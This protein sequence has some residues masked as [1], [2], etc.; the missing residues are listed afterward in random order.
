RL[1]LP[2]RGFEHAAASRSQ[3]ESILLRMGFGD[4]SEG[5]GQALPRDYVTGESI[6]SVI[7]D[8]TGRLW[9]AFVERF[10]R[11][12]PASLEDLSAAIDR[13]RPDGACCNA[14]AGA[15]EMA[16]AA[17]LDVLE[18][19]TRIG[20]RVSGVL[21][22]S[23]PARTQKRLKL[24]RWF[25]LRDFKLKLGLG[26]DVDQENLRIV[27]G[28]LG[29]AIRRGRCSLRVD[30]N[31][32]WQA[33]ELPERSAYLKSVGVCVIEQPCFVPAGELVELAGK[34][35]L[36]LM[37][38]ESLLTPADADLLADGGPGIWWNVRIG[39]N[40]GVW[41]AIQLLQLAR[42][43]QIS[44]TF[45]CMVGEMS[46]LSAWQRVALARAG[47]NVRFV[48]GNYGRFLLGQDPF[49][50]SLRFGFGGRLGKVRPGLVRRLEL[51]EKSLEKLG[52][53]IADLTV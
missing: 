11:G 13:P 22:S 30:V 28:R 33:D 49:D 3:A 51:D 32:G 1:S 46:V 31:G 17:A 27:H 37:A 7:D 2:M 36:P 47:Q 5:F 43:R 10:G 20:P 45:G 25:G 12:L 44:V 48:E 38:D 40:G 19:P 16:A 21:G 14:A 35:H 34:S 6:E 8:L 9:P 29:R 39:K 50:P 24:M 53:K 4:G 18:A 42:A 41:P 52:R 23:D 15:L 26:E